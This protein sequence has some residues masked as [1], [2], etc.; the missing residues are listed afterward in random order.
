MLVVNQQY[1]LPPLVHIKSQE[2]ELETLFL[3]LYSQIT[4]E[5][6]LIVEMR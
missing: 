3:Q 6:T 1:Y 5:A 2:L 4:R